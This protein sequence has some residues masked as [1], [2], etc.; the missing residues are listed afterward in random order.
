M[1]LADRVLILVIVLVLGAP[2]ATA[3]LRIQ[4]SVD[5]LRL[6]DVGPCLGA[7]DSF[8]LINSGTR[9]VPSP[10]VSVIPGFRVEAETDDNIVVGE[11]R[12]IYAT[13]IGNA[14]VQSY[15]SRYIL[16]VTIQGESSSDTVLIQ[17]RRLAG[18]CCVFRVDTIKGRAG[19]EVSIRILQDSTQPGTY[20]SDMTS[21]MHVGFDPTT[22]V[23]MGV[24]P[25]MIDRENGAFTIR[26]RLRDD[27]GVLASV[28]ARMT[29]GEVIRSEARIVWHSN[30]DIRLIDTTY[31]GPVELLGVCLDKGERL[32]DPNNR[33]IRVIVGDGVINVES[34]HDSNEVVAVHD[35]HGRVVE[36][37]VVAPGAVVAIRCLRGA[38]LVR[39][40]GQRSRMVLV[41]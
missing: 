10:G 39:V 25:Q 19:D 5:T 7:R 32:F 13:F 29:L 36:T 1:K 40:G 38:Y 11:S 2:I 6:G 21:T 35:L 41:P 28:P 3:Q 14:V 9:D 30:S 27:N 4:F 31:A 17:A 15:S 24:I 37:T 8:Y 26:V 20:L 18:R 23:P 22:L 34:H 33:S 12:K 16:N